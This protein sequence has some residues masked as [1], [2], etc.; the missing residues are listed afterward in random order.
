M[1]EPMKRTNIRSASPLEPII[2]FSRAVRIGDHIAIGGTAP[3]GP[4]GKCT[5]VGDVVA[6]TRRCFAIIDAALREAGASFADV[7]RTRILLTRI[8][9]W[10][11][12]AAIHGEIFS[13]IRPVTTVVEVSRFVDPDWLVEIEVDAI[14]ATR[15]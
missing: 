12:V 10:K 5:G 14:V 6:Q 7:T 9:D 2:G 3:L 4:D 8:A 13:A 15:R 11:A 1:S